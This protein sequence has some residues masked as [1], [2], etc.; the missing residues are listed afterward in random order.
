MA[1]ESRAKGPVTGQIVKYVPSVGTICPAI[2]TSV[3]RVD[4]TIG[5]TFFLDQQ[6]PSFT[7]EVPYDYTAG[8]LVTPSWH[9]GEDLF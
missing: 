9:W 3:S 7:N 2:V 4:G 8:A 1:T 5:I 6:A